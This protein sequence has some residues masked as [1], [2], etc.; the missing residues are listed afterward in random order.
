MADK[1]YY[2]TA[3]NAPFQGAS[4]AL[5]E[6]DT[7]SATEHLLHAVTNAVRRAVQAGQCPLE[8]YRQALE[9]L[10]A[11]PMD[12]RCAFVF[13]PLP[14]APSKV[15]EL[16]RRALMDIATE[17]QF[18]DQA[19]SSLSEELLVR[20]CLEVQEFELLTRLE[21]N[22]EL[23][24]SGASPDSQAELAKVRAETQEQFRELV[25]DHG[26][27]PKLERF[28]TDRPKKVEFDPEKPTVTFMKPRRQGGNP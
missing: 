24:I 17:I 10:V 25:R 11:L 12:E 27:S 28:K 5:N 14:S 4:A 21:V 26:D 8:D 13:E 7:D 6:G 16:A 18:L 20:T 3:I 9:R 1:D 22:I 2:C 19:P 15:G 23:G